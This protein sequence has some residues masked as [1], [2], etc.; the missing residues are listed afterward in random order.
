MSSVSLMGVATSNTR[1][2]HF[3]CDALAVGLDSARPRVLMRK[4][5]VGKFR[6]RFTMAHELGRVTLAWHVGWMICSPIR[7]AFD[8]RVT[9]QESEANRFASALLIP[10]RFLEERSSQHLGGVVSALDEAQVSAAAAVLALARNLLPGFSFLIDEDEDGF[11]LISSSGTTVPGGVSRGPQVAELRDKAHQSGEAIVSGR[12]VLW[13][14]FATQSD[15]TVP[16]DVRGT[17]DILRQVLSSI[18]A[19]SEVDK[20]A[21]R[22]NG[23]VGGM[24]GKEGRAQGESQALAALEQRFSSDPALEYLMDIPDFRLYLKRKA[25]DRV[26]RRS[27][28]LGYIQGE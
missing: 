26:R 13:F 21:L 25:A 27:S 7:T 14:K 8:A 15:F 22:I 20:L 24:L 1:H 12:R 9:E 4:D 28:L 11:R 19:S 18:V 5:G 6:R 23:I 3:A 2:G 17:T 10:R 16:E